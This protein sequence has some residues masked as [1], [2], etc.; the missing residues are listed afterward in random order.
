[1]SLKSNMLPLPEI[2]TAGLES[3]IGIKQTGHFSRMLFQLLAA[4][5]YLGNFFFFS[6]LSASLYPVLTT[7]ITSF[8]AWCW[9]KLYQGKAWSGK[10]MCCQN[11]DF[12]PDIPES[13]ASKLNEQAPACGR[14]GDCGNAEVPR[15][16]RAN[17]Q[18][19][20]KRLLHPAPSLMEQFQTLHWWQPTA[21]H[22]REMQSENSFNPHLD[23][24]IT[25]PEGQ[26]SKHLTTLLFPHQMTLFHFWAFKQNMLT[27][28][29]ARFLNKPQKPSVRLANLQ[30]QKK[31]VTM[32]TDT[33]T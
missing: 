21:A 30:A 11:S 19:F 29:H 18:K 22:Q 12:C 2:N 24:T 6:L 8:D 13:S 7:D 25:R 15:G 4:R 16:Y 31:L 9:W 20:S 5:W 1:M 3:T 14:Q 27:G 10:Q 26:L 28:L 33:H 23:L 17:D 32:Q